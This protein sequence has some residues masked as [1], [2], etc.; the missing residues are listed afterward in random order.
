MSKLILDYLKVLIWPIVVITVIFIF[1][2]Q[3][4]DVAKRVKKAEIYGVS[5]EVGGNIGVETE[6][7]TEKKPPATAFNYISL[8]HSISG[9]KCLEISRTTLSENG[10]EEINEGVGNTIYGYYKDYVGLL[11]CDNYQNLTFIV[12]SGPIYHESNKRREKLQST[13]LSKLDL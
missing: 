2:G 8:P 5:V 6:T 3:I 11:W 10:F 7:T 12:V 1:R 9:K 4:K 13:F